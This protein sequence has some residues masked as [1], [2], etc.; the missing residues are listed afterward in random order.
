MEQVQPELLVHGIEN[1]WS[2]ELDKGGG[3]YFLKNNSVIVHGIHLLNVPSTIKKKR[4]S[5]GLS[6]SAILD[7]RSV[8]ITNSL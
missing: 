6:S 2:V 8:S 7:K 1:P 5:L 4:L 3:V